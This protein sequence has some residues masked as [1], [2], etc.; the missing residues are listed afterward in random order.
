MG[1]GS[2]DYNNIKKSGIGISERQYANA[3][4]EWADGESLSAHYAYGCDVFCTNDRGKSAGSGS[5]FHLNNLPKLKEHF[6]IVVL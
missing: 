3:V 1:C 5:I 4:A 6:G 2:H